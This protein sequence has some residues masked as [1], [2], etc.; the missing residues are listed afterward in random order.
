M[1][2]LDHCGCTKTMHRLECRRKKRSGE[3][4]DGDT[5][6]GAPARCGPGDLGQMEGYASQLPHCGSLY[7]EG[8]KAYEADGDVEYV[9]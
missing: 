3:Y 6:P 7:F 5:W 1:I 9:S 4:V 2:Q 8:D